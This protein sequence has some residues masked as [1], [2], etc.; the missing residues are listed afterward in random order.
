MKFYIANHFKYNDENFKCKHENVHP[1]SRRGPGDPFVKC[2]SMPAK[3]DRS[4]YGRLMLV[5]DDEGPQRGGLCLS[6]KYAVKTF[7]YA[8]ENLKTDLWSLA[9]TRIFL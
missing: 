1:F 7:S 2:R 5:V 9:G 8:R 3:Y 4:L 6:F